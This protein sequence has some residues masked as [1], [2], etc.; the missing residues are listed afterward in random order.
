[1]AGQ[2]DDEIAL[3]GTRPQGGV[4]GRSEEKKNHFRMDTRAVRLLP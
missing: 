2:L 4:S 3:P 1:M